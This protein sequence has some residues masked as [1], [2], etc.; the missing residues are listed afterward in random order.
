MPTLP[1][2]EAV[3]SPAPGITAKREVPLH[4]DI[5]SQTQ[6]VLKLEVCMAKLQGIWGP[7]EED[8]HHLIAGTRMQL[9]EAKSM[10][11]TMRQS[12]TLHA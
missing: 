4:A 6:Y 11:Q 7:D 5:V 9:E 2:G 10:L 3:A 1:V 12:R 8:G